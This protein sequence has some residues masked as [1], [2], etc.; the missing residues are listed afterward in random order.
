[1][2]KLPNIYKYTDNYKIYLLDILNLNSKTRGFQKKMADSAGCTAPY[3]NQVLRGNIHLTPEHMIG[4]SELLGHTAAEKEYLMA[5]THYSRSG[6]K[7]LQD[8]Y[9]KIL[10]TKVKEQE[11]LS[12]RLQK[13]IIT[14]ESKNNFFYSSWIWLA[15]HIVL[16][17][18]RFRTV[19]AISHRFKLDV[20]FVQDCLQKLAE[21]GMA[22]CNDYGEWKTEL[23][24]I[25][26]GQD[27]NMLPIHHQH[28]R[29][30]AAQEILFPQAESIH[31]SNVF[32]ISQNDFQQL[33]ELTFRYIDHQQNIISPSSE[34][35]IYCFTLDFFKL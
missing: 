16:T 33:R 25:H 34:E 10:T 20:H 17:I 2:N 11:N 3:L 13:Q 6:T 12:A 15:L 28:W 19:Q 22:T 1:M 24:D 23:G 7:K 5:L 26:L 14:E 29:N 32:S 30:R 31:F 8:F 18:P 9:L 27:S 35:E 4:I 21:R